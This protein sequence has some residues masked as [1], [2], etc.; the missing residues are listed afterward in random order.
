MRRVI[1][2]LAAAIALAAE[3]AAAIDAGTASGHYAGEEAKIA[4][5][6][7]AAALALD[8][9]EG[10]LDSP[11]VM[12]VLLSQEEVP[13]SAL[14][15]LVF[16]PAH[17]MAKAGALHGLLLQFDPA[18]RNGV[19][20]TI[21]A[22]PTE[23]GQSF[24]TLTLS[25]TEGVW[26][27]LEVSATR[28]IGELKGS[29]TFDVAAAFSAPVFTN[30]VQ[31]DLK[32]AAAQQSEPVRVLAARFDAIAKGDLAAAASLSTKG[33]AA[34]LS[35]MP[36]E[37]MKQARAQIPLLARQIRTA[38]RVVIR[39]DTAAVQTNEGGWFSL[40]LENGAWKAAD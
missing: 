17:M 25:S 40:A 37:V 34:Q 8:N 18:D 1:L 12:R 27:R 5:L 7:H 30:P 39:K 9:A 15:G 29:E 26:K 2:V 10:E 4:T 35:A 6:T 36:A 20:V 33:S 21:L 22:M 31:Q 28:I 13:P 16:T 3:P 14:A 32:G 11:Q 19:Y 23:P 24:T 38:K